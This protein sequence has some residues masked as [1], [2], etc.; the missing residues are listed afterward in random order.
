[1]DRVL[2]IED[3]PTVREVL[4]SYL[5]AAGLDVQ[6]AADGLGGLAKFD[7]QPADV[8]VLDLMLPGMDG[9][10]VFRQLRSRNGTLAVMML[11]A[12]GAEEDRILGLQ[13][14]ADDYVT[15]PFSNRE[16]VL[17][18]QALLR[19]SATGSGDIEPEP[20]I[21]LL[22]DGDITVDTRSRIARR[23]TTTMLLT[24]R[25]FDLLAHFLASPGAVWSRQDLLSTVWGWEYGDESTVTVHV[26]RLRSKVE[27]DP[28][29]PRRLVTV[30]GAGYRWDSD[31]S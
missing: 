12:K 19:R 4:C 27:T 24:A 16:I 1:M 17:R 28:A 25:E 21:T 15:K 7:A 31:G 5:L 18:V 6:N 3:D 14:G 11:T 13:M 9:L 22:T 29:R 26:R 8:V 2:V 30:W 10:E 23:G 20:A